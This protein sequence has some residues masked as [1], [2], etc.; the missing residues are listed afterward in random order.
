MSKK[1]NIE[2]LFRQKM[3]NAEVT[4]PADVKRAIDKALNFP[5]SNL[6]YLKYLLL[7]FIIIGT[8]AA[9]FYFGT[10]A[11][12]KNELSI[13]DSTSKNS[14]SSLTTAPN[15]N[16]SEKF[17]SSTEVQPQHSEISPNAGQ[18]SSDTLSMNSENSKFSKTTS[19]STGLSAQNSN[20]T[21]NGSISAANSGES[22]K[23]SKGVNSSSTS[24]TTPSSSS[25]NN[26]EPNK[27]AASQNEVNTTST[28]DSNPS[29]KNENGTV[30]HASSSDSTSTNSNTSA[31]AS[32][33]NV[34]GNANSVSTTATSTADSLAQVS[35]SSDNGQE[36]ATTKNEAEENKPEGKKKPSKIIEG[37]SIGIDLSLP[38]FNTS[39]EIQGIPSTPIQ[40][41]SDIYTY[42]S[43]LMYELYG[44]IKAF[45]GFHG[46]IGG[47]YQHANSTFTSDSS[48]TTFTSYD[49]IVYIYD[50]NGQ[51]IIDSTIYT[52]YD[53]TTVVKNIELQ[54]A[55]NY[56]SIPISVGRTF[57]LNPNGNGQLILMS[58]L[59]ADLRFTRVTGD[60]PTDLTVNP[61]TMNFT[62]RNTLAY[63]IGDFY[64]MLPIQ[65][66]YAPK[67]RLIYQETRIDPKSSLG[68][69]LGIQYNF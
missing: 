33:N 35:D 48:Y 23:K 6:R 43:V 13:S 63:E 22:S 1:N 64:I 28:S 12:S 2:D 52:N 17:S 39:Q 40:P 27:N 44:Q 42:N 29:Q 31:N 36:V 10:N 55:F 4:P 58:N 38:K 9:A 47:Q 61:F 7:L 21:K 54:N 49:S 32:S 19:T 11:D 25:K 65:V 50:T 51:T 62:L 67:S 53:S 57:V 14:T 30:N 18:N 16:T 24:N 34:G 69:G 41:S 46:Q 59:G 26:E 20:P 45:N 66:N 60:L 68:I 8:G 5:S 15:P 56:Y 3:G 37:Y